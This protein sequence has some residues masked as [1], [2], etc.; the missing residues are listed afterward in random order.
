MIRR[1]AY[2]TAI[3]ALGLTLT[4]CA[5]NIFGGLGG[6]PRAAWRDQEEAACM[7][8]RA[9]VLQS[10]YVVPESRINGR[11]ACGISHPLKISAFQGGTIAVGPTATLGCPMAAFLD[12]W[13]RDSV[14][15]A[16]LAWFGSPVVGI[17]QISNYSCRPIDNIRG[18]K[19]SEH[20]YGNALDIAAFKLANGREV[21]V[22]KGWRGANDEQGFLREVEATACQRF[23]T[24]LGPG[25]RYHA[26]HFHLD[27]AHHG[28]TGTSRYCNPTPQVVPPMRAPVD[29]ARV[30]YL[31]QA[32]GEML[33]SG[34]AGCGRP[35]PQRSPWR[36][37]EPAG[38]RGAAAAPEAGLLRQA[39]RHRLAGAAGGR[40][41]VL[42]A[43][44]AQVVSLATGR[45]PA[46]IV[47]SAS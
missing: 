3:A 19:L 30:A 33:Q 23:K 32:P 39:A 41:A 4:G 12:A 20:S 42:R 37:S 7:A 28:R 26:N 6:E 36:L 15:P 34:A 11:G 8:S 10:A 18:K 46:S 17:R 13:F 2:L 43:V 25:E 14:Q 22:L 29:G 40:A 38:A 5:L 47:G 45:R 24:V 9:P 44:T 21:T 1:V 31:E 27:L 16:A 35:E